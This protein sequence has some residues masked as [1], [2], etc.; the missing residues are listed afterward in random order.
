MDVEGILPEGE[1]DKVGKQASTS[2]GYDDVD[3]SLGA[4]AKIT[5]ARGRKGAVSGIT[6]TDC[7]YPSSRTRLRESSDTFR[8]WQP[9]PRGIDG[10]R[11]SKRLHRSVRRGL[12]IVFTCLFWCSGGTM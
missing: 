1:G 2:G 3:R 10:S 7:A 4:N 9:L 11:L 6:D 8:E 12:E 5:T